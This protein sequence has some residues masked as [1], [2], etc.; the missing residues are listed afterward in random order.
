MAISDKHTQDPWYLLL[1]DKQELWP[2]FFVKKILLIV[3]TI[4]DKQTR[5]VV[6]VFVGQTRTVAT[7]SVEKK[8][9]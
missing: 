4:S 1:Q 9:S 2:L 8:D 3:M 7:F 6:V 5:S